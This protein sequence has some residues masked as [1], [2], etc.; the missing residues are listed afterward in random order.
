M[1]ESSCHPPH[2]VPP[3]FKPAPQTSKDT[4]PPQDLPNRSG[5]ERRVLRDLINHIRQVRK[6]IP[7]VPI[8]QDGRDP[9]VVE[10]YLVIADFDEVDDGVGGHEG[11]EGRLDDSADGALLAKGS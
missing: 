8:R 7:L 5:I 4:K 11:R 2:P 9:G 1:P 6:Q 3:H 10:F